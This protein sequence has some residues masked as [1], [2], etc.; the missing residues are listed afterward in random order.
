MDGFLGG[1]I[2]QWVLIDSISRLLYNLS[3]LQSDPLR[4]EQGGFSDS[5]SG[6]GSESGLK[7]QNPI[8]FGVEVRRPRTCPDIYLYI[9]ILLS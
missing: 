3:Y 7:F 4:P 6:I 1:W 8:G 9:I 2:D 5:F